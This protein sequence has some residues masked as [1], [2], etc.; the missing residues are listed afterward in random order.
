MTGNAGSLYRF[1]IHDLNN[2]WTEVLNCVS[3]N[4]GSSQTASLPDGPYR[5]KIYNASWT[6]ICDQDVN[7]SGGGSCI[8]ADSDGVCAAADCNDNNAN[9][10]ATPGTS[11]ND[12][13][14]N[15]T[16]DVIL[17]DGCTCQGTMTGG[18]SNGT[19]SDI[20]ITA[21]ANTIDITGLT[22]P[23]EIIKIYR[24]N[25][26][27]QL[28]YDCVANCGTQQSITNLVAGNYVVE[29]QFFTASWSSV[30]SV[31]ETLVVSNFDSDNGAA[32]SFLIGNSTAVNRSNKP[33]RFDL[34]PNPAQEKIWVNLSNWENQKLELKI[35]NHLA[36]VV[37]Q[38]S[39]NHQE[40][41]VHPVDI[42]NLGNGL[43]FVQIS[44]GTQTLTKKLFI[45]K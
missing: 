22:A 13:N 9:L 12:N 21:S 15:T 29:V 11:C 7:L 37:V 32:P 18:G 1:K 3:S 43:H 27:W 24:V 20:S 31:Q 23:I 42:P 30:C 26:G 41:M 38:Y 2:G 5:V 17:E 44:N 6:I 34:Y 35:V 25:N 33:V 4:C 16:N 14:S 40:G 36:Q 8:D 28:E 10:P 19:C 39:I 45:S